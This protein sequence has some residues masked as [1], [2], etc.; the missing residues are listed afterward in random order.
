MVIAFAEYED[1]LQGLKFGFHQL[2]LQMVLHLVEQREL[3]LEEVENDI[4]MCYG[5][6]EDTETYTY[7]SYCKHMMKNRVWCDIVALKAIAQI[8]LGM[9]AYQ[10]K[11]IL[12]CCSMGTM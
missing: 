5:G 3:M 10:M 4:K 6:F 12:F 8:I 7:K 11:Q 1:Y 9:K 2:R